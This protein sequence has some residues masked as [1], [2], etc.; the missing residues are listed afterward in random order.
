MNSTTPVNTERLTP[1]NTELLAPANTER[2]A[3]ANI[4]L[5]A[6]AKDAATAMAAIDHGA[7]AIYMGASAF[8][9]RSQAGNNLAE[10]QQVVDYAHRFGVRV[11][12]TVNTIVYESELES[13]RQLVWQLW[14]ADV[15]ALIVQDLALTQMQLPPIALHASTQCDTRTPEKAK[16][17]ESCGFTRIVLAR[18]LT[19]QEIAAIRNAVKADLEVFVHG[20]LCVS[21]SG[22]CQASYMVTGRS[23]NR[24]E[25]CQ[26]CRFKFDLEDAAGNTLVRGKH[27]LSLRDMNRLDN[28]EAL[29]EAGAVSLKIEGRLKDAAYVKNVVGAYRRELDRIIAAHPDKYRRASFGTTT[30]TFTPDPTQSFNRGFTNYFLTTT[31]PAPASLATFNSPKWT[32]KEVGTVRRMAGKAIV[33][34]LKAELHNGDGLGYYTPD[35]EFVG[36]RLNK[37]DGDRLLPA[38]D[39]SIPSGTILYR[40]SDKLRSDMLA[41]NTA[42]RKIAVAISLF[43]KNGQLVLTMRSENGT[44]IA[45][46]EAIEMQTARSPQTERR[47]KEL[48][49]LGDTIFTAAEIADKCGDLFIPA[50]TLSRLRR[51]ATDILETSLRHT[52]RIEKPGKPSANPTLPEGYTLTRHDNIANSLSSSFY[53]RITGTDANDLPR[54]IE[55][56]KDAPAD[57][58][59]PEAAVR[60]MQTRYCLRREMGACLKTKEGSKLHSRLYL[61]SEGK[62]FLLDFDCRNC[63]M[64]VNYIK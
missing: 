9:A 47:R 36:F 49:K 60:V 33:A 29:L 19:L 15:D 7:D 11:Y 64:T 17:L 27:L 21:Y 52:H 59:K 35:G 41:G 44:E 10:I 5:L 61:T 50:S 8:G 40:N 24:G 32:G 34:R 4:E 23:A 55:V 63:R 22:D 16:F 58:R 62:R 26:V 1:A 30:L 42:E 48:E 31:N 54:A 18:E 45:V 39:I 2:P 56:S 51:N 53:A 6:P 3:P 13:V 37:I 43:E 38:S 46:A 25:C 12:V 57:I 20:A 14:R 28:L